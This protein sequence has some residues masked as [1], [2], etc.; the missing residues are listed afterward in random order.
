MRPRDRRR[1]DW[2]DSVSDAVLKIMEPIVQRHGFRM[3]DVFSDQPAVKN[4]RYVCMREL[5]LTHRYK[6][7]EI[8][9]VFNMHH[10]TVYYAT[11]QNNKNESLQAQH[12]HPVDAS[13]YRS[14]LREHLWVK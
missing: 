12:H 2:M 8:A 7:Q 14:N 3:G 13:L 5:R 1:P 11:K 10:S 9:D 6:L 4:V